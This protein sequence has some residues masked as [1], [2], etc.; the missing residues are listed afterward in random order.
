MRCDDVC[1]RMLNQL[2][3]VESF[4]WESKE[5]LVTTTQ[6]RSD[7][8]INQYCS[9]KRTEGRAE[10]VDVMKVEVGG[11]GDTVDLGSEEESAVQD[12]SWVL[13]WRGGKNKGLSKGMSKL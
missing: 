6:A 1:G 12:D 5:A 13:N 9:E 11:A 4:L 3:F 2:K 8:D 7:E 10:T